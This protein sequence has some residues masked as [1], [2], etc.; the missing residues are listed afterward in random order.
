MAQGVV[1][2]H[3]DLASRD[4]LADTARQAAEEGAQRRIR[5]SDRHRRQ[6]HSDAA[7]LPERRVR[8]DRT[9][10]PETLLLGARPSQEVKCWP[11]REIGPT[12]ADQLQ[13]QIGPVDLR[14]VD[15]EHGAVLTSKAF[16]CRLRAGGS[17][18]TG[19]A[20]SMRFSSI[21]LSQATTFS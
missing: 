8:E 16:G 5:T 10:P 19:F 4:G 18:P 2:E 11:R 7:R 21:F 3:R 6:P 12:L 1:E 15:P 17:S 9:F 20:D 13:R 14:Q